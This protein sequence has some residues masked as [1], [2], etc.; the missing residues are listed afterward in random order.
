MDAIYPGQVPLHKV[1]FN[2]KFEYEFVANFKVLQSIFDKFGI[3]RHIPVDKLVKAKY[4]DNLEFVQWMKRYYD[5]HAS[6][7]DYN[8][9]ERRREAAAKAPKGSRKQAAAPPTVV[10]AAAATTTTAQASQPVVTKPA[11]ARKENQPLQP[12]QKS[13]GSDG[14][15]LKELQEQVTAMKLTIDGLEKERDF[16]FGKLREI[17]IQCQNNE[18][19]YPDFVKVI[20]K[21]LYATDDEFVAADEVANV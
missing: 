14:A 5:T 15:R 18:T 4:Q 1:N 7:T 9:V 13:R 17:E 12:V 8:A 6:N 11:V 20:E 3:D 2:A 16:Y 19:V 21:I 10:P